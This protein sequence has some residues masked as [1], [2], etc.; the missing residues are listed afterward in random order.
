MFIETLNY[1]ILVMRE[2]GLKTKINLVGILSYM[3]YIIFNLIMDL[4]YNVLIATL[5]TS[6]LQTVILLFRYY[7]VIQLFSDMVLI[8]YDYLEE[9]QSVS[10]RY[11]FHQ[12]ARIHNHNMFVSH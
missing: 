8:N 1:Q 10:R 9:S 12:P 5:N 2:I 7:N 3:H 11:C 4:A 6:L